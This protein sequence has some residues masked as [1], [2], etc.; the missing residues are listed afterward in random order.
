MFVT[1]DPP[2]VARALLASLTLNSAGGVMIVR[3][4]YIHI[5][6]I[7]PDFLYKTVY[8]SGLRLLFPPPPLSLTETNVSK[9]MSRYGQ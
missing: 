6:E 8:V 5:L 7:T 4:P 3:I 1:T 9:A 2:P